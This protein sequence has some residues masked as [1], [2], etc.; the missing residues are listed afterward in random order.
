M[1]KAL[2]DTDIFSE[3]LKGIDP[4]VAAQATAYRVIFGRYTVSTITVLEIVKGLHK[5]QRE[6]RIQQF[7][8]G[9]T[10][11]EVLTLGVQSAELAER[12]RGFLYEILT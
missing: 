12:S 4:N 2:L 11:V 3:I 1:D 8:D 6:D 10:A 7:L 5:M 9:L